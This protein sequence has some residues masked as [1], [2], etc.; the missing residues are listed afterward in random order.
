MV[1][2]RKLE[3]PEEKPTIGDQEV[4]RAAIIF[5]TSILEKFSISLSFDFTSSSSSMK[6]SRHFSSSG[7]GKY[8][9]F[10][11][12]TPVVSTWHPS[13]L[14]SLFMVLPITVLLSLLARL[15][16]SD[17]S[18]LLLLHKESLNFINLLESLGVGT[19]TN[20]YSDIGG[21]CKECQMQSWQ[22]NLR[23]WKSCQHHWS[24]DPINQTHRN[25]RQRCRRSWSSQ[26][27]QHSWIL[28][29]CTYFG[30]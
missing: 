20:A 29:Y 19:Q 15:A 21:M 25:W 16:S 30:F 4:Q 17:T 22:I 13:S 12:T 6:P 11:L 24:T 8:S 27:G 14:F 28:K 1:C 10:F 18:I 9:M 23:I 7:M 3:T 26:E 2:G 5:W